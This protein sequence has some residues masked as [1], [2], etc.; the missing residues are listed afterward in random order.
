MNILEERAAKREEL[1]RFAKDS[2]VNRIAELYLSMYRT[3]LEHLNAGDQ[4]EAHIPV[5]RDKF[6][7][8]MKDVVSQ[9]FPNR[10]D[11][12]ENPD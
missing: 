12:L 6:L 11:R 1:V 9:F 10:P 3:D 8:W 2:N 5:G 4:V 7:N